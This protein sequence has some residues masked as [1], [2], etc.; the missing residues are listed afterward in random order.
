MVFLICGKSGAGKT[1]YAMNLAEELT[2]ECLVRVL[3]GDEQRAVSG[4]ND[5]S[6]AGRHR[7]LMGM[8]RA[9]SHAESLGFVVIVAAIAPKAIWRRE[10][11]AMW[12]ESRLVYLPGGT[13][14]E[15]TIFER[16][17]FDEF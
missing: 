9:A 16:P 5:Y 11:R 8:A 10:M 13:L 1:T 4:N 6:D 14:W 15:G 17:K 2:T 7:H 3:D 12:R